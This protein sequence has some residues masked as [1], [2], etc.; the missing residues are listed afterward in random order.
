MNADT[1]K[2]LI[3]GIIKE[4]LQECLPTMI[5]KVLSEI[6]SG[7]TSGNVISETITRKSS[8]LQSAVSNKK[9]EPVQSK[10]LKRYTQNEV[11]NK[12]LNETKPGLPQM[13]SYVGYDSE[14]QTEGSGPGIIAEQIIPKTDEQAAVLNVITKDFRS[15][16]KAID[17]KKSGGMGMAASV[18]FDPSDMKFD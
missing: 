1:L 10:Q 12:I 13:G 18:S 4:E 7:N 3:R 8:P 9:V 16:M 17:K 6:L 2:K 15:V 14:L 5:P 11:L